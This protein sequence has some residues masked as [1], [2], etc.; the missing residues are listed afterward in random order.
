MPRYCIYK[1]CLKQLTFNSS[2]EKIA[3]Y[4]SEHKKENMIN[5]RDKRCSYENC[6]KR[7]S[8]KF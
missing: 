2:N 5:V 1:D 6:L 7:P 8:F 4:C 3:I